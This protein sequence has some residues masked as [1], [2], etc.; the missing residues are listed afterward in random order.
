MFETQY[1]AA[2]TLDFAILN[3]NVKKDDISRIK[4]HVDEEKIDAF[5][6]KANVSTATIL[7]YGISYFPK[8]II[9]IAERKNGGIIN[10]MIH[11]LNVH[12]Q[13]T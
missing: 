10:L 3:S 4:A 1:V 12:T 7:P 8:H 13:V 6:K 11:E 2:V 9:L 5:A